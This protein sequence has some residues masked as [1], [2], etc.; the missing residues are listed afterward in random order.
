M[1]FVRKGG[2]VARL[3]FSSGKMAVPSLQG[4]RGGHT[5][6]TSQ[7]FPLSKVPPLHTHLLQV[8]SLKG[9]GVEE[10]VKG[11]GEEVRKAGRQEEENEQGMLGRRGC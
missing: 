9:L 2:R 3:P 4:W 5:F 10:L 1:E 11:R 7:F 8:I 6:I